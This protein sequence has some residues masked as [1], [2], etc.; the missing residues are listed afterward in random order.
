MVDVFSAFILSCSEEKVFAINLLSNLKS[1]W[2][3][4]NFSRWRKMLCKQISV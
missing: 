4:D 3:R 2:S 1:A